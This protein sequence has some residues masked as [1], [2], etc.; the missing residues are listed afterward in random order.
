MCGLLIC[1]ALIVQERVSALPEFG[2][3]CIP[4]FTDPGLSSSVAQDM[5]TKYIDESTAALVADVCFNLR[6]LSDEEFTPV[7]SGCFLD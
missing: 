4:F 3:L 2:P 5:K 6:N 1:F 7:S